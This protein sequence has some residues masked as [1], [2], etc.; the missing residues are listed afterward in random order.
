MEGFKTYLQDKQLVPSERIP[1]YAVWVSKYIAFCESQDQK[2]LDQTQLTELF[3]RQLNRKYEDWQVAQAAEAVKLYRYYRRR[4]R[5]DHADSNGGA[6]AQWRQVAEETVRMLRLKHRSMST[7]KTYLGWLRQFYR[8]LDGQAPGDIDASHL[9]DFLSHLAVNR[10]VSRATQNQAFNAI[11]FVFRHVLDKDVDEIRTVVRARTRRRLPVVLTQAEVLRIF[12]HLQNHNRLMAQLIYGCGLRLMECAR[13]RIKDVDFER[14]CLT[15]KSGKGDKDRMTMLPESLYDELRAQLEAGRELYDE[16][17]AADVA[18]VWLPDALAR[19]YPNAGKEWAWFWVFP[20]QKLSVDPRS[21]MVR[22]HHVSANNLQKQFRRAVARAGIAKNATVHTLRHS[23]AT[24]LLE[25][26]YDIRSIQ[27]LLGHAHVQTTM[28]YTHVA[29][30]NV[31]GV[32]SPLD[33]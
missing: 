12:E 21:R 17:R 18:G 8:F 4:T 3:I 2:G 20:S 25:K 7:E 33:L 1:F 23:F 32:R 28:I 27:E 13:L 26:G 5:P 24:H 19:K 11:L 31:L 15:V 22:R 16:D 29:R 14:G 30:K 9:K 10:N 6:K